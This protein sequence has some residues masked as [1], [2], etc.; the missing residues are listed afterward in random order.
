MAMGPNATGQKMHQFA[1][2]AEP[3]TS[4]IPAFEGDVLRPLHHYFWQARSGARFTVVA[5]QLVGCPA[6]VAASY[7]LVKC[8]AG[9]EPKVVGFGR[10]TDTAASV[11]LA[12]IR[13]HGALLGAD[14][15]HLFA[16]Q[17]TPSTER[18]CGSVDEASTSAPIHPLRTLAPVL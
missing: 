18:N 1:V 8:V 15:V 6:P 16:L 14:E 17:G 3:Q 13:R 5:Y 11:N 4:R 9:G 2:S 12:T 7:L 10:V